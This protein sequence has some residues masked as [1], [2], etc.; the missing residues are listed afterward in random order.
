M[1]KFTFIMLAVSLF[2]A[3]IISWFASPHPDG[4]ERVAEN[5]GFID[6]AVDSFYKIMPD[7]TIPGLNGF[8]SN[9]LSGI[10][11]TLITFAFVFLVIRLISRKNK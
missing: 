11:G 4:L 7:Y 6:K 10:L 9:F 1:K 8:A 5:H 2:I 3:G